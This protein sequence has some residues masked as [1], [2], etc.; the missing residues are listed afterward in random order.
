MGTL[1]DA[2][3]QQMKTIKGA[4]S[5]IIEEEINKIYG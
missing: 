3:Q 1:H 5:R 2:F 4:T